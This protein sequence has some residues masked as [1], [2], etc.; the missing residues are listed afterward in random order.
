M[1]PRDMQRDHE[2]LLA[3]SSYLPGNDL[4][5]Q[6]SAIQVPSALE[7]LTSVFGMGTGG[8]PPALS[9]DLRVVLSKLH[10]V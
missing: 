7:V 2:F 5:S 9:P 6:D 8:T 10:S 3:V 4:L 1:E